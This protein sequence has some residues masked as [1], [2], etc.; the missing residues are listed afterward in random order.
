MDYWVISFP[1]LLYLASFGTPR[2]PRKRA[3]IFSTDVTNTALG[4]VSIYGNIVPG[5]FLSDVFGL[6]CFSISVGLNV[7][8]TLMIVIRLIV[9]SRNFRK[10]VG[11]ST[12]PAGELYN[13]LVTAIIESFALSAVAYLVFIGSWRTRNLSNIIGPVLFGAQVCTLSAISIHI[14][15]L[16]NRYLITVVNRSLLRSSSFYESRIGEH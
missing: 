10:A 12:M 6:S 9:H 13:F 3:A 14:T 15:T 16:D 4:I 5:F 11:A 1:C 8:L 2:S 7:L